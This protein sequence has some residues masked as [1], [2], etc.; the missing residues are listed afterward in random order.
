MVL[1]S[2]GC[3]YL[4][5]SYRDVINKAQDPKN[6]FWYD[7]H[8]GYDVHSGDNGN[9]EGG[10]GEKANHCGLLDLWNVKRDSVTHCMGYHRRQRGAMNSECSMANRYEEGGRRIHWD[11]GGTRG[12][13]RRRQM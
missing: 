2:E 10:G 9:Y 12:N 13:D 7:V 11:T 1:S 8:G 6:C 3:A 4:E 5:G